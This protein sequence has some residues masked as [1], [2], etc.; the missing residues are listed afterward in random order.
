MNDCTSEM[1]FPVHKEKPE[2][3]HTFTSHASYASIKNYKK[4]LSKNREKIIFFLVRW[5]KD[6]Q[7]QFQPHT[8]LLSTFCLVHK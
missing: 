5:K 6:H 1:T 7:Q 3:L 2:H 8:Q 4:N